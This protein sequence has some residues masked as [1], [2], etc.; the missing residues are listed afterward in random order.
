MY[1]AV[2]FRELIVA[3]GSF[4][5]VLKVFRRLERGEKAMVYLER[6]VH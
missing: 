1:S 2:S 3:A 4:R 5:S 6:R